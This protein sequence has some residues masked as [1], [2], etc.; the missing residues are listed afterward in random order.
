MHAN[1]GF[2]ARQSQI[3]KQLLEYDGCDAD[4]GDIAG[5]TVHFPI[6]RLFQKPLSE[7]AVKALA[8]FF[9]RK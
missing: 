2:V 1:E 5:E 8:Y 4:G 9:L 7:C 3:V 6:D